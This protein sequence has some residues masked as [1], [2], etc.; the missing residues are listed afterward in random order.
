MIFPHEIINY[1]SRQVIKNWNTDDVI[2]SIPDE[3]NNSDLSGDL[4]SYRFP[5]KIPTGLLGPIV[6][7]NRTLA[8]IDG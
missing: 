2:N 6:V 1:F 3:V 5:P 4:I 8:E 7:W